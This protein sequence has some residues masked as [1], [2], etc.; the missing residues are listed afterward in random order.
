MVNLV[1]TLGTTR[2]WFK[3]VGGYV[4]FKSEETRESF[5]FFNYL[6][7]FSAPLFCFYSIGKGYEFVALA[8][9]LLFVIHPLVDVILGRYL[10]ST[11][12]RLFSGLSAS[13]LYFI[14]ILLSVPFQLAM[15]IYALNVSQYSSSD[16]VMAGMLCGFSGGILGVGVSHELIHRRSQF[17][18]LYGALMLLII[19]YAHFFPEHLIHHTKLA[20]SKDADTAK[21]NESVYRFIPRSIYQGWI[22]SWIFK[23]KLMTKMVVAQIIVCCLIVFAF[24]IPGFILFTVQGLVAI[25]MLKWVNYVEHYGVFRNPRDKITNRHSWDSTNELTNFSLLNLGFHSKHHMNAS[26]HY[27]D[28]PIKG[29]DWNELPAGYSAMMMCALWPRYWKSIMNPL[30]EKRFQSCHV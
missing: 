5:K 14:P 16:A 10:S 11:I 15:L 30:V 17:E 24:G 25:M 19:N 8:F 28:L 20:T 21:K 4:S 23:T 29:S 7:I 12:K 6:N 3:C 27:Q 13:S 2:Y 1:E 9:V 26:I 18:K 22:N